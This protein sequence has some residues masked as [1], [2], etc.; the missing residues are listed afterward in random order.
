MYSFTVTS[1]TVDVDHDQSTV[2]TIVNR[3]G[4]CDNCLED[5]G[6]ALACTGHKPQGTRVVVLGGPHSGKSVFVASLWTS[7]GGSYEWVSV[8][9]DGEGPVFHAMTVAGDMEGARAYKAKHKGQWSLE[10]A[11]DTS[12]KVASMRTNAILDAGGL[13][14]EWNMVIASQA[15]YAIVLHKGDDHAVDSRSA[16]LQWCGLMGLPVLHCIHSNMDGNDA[17]DAISGLNRGTTHTDKPATKA[18]SFLLTHT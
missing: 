12:H 4:Q 2:T 15:D 14:S 9:P 1:I 17:Y 8:C 13:R 6:P 10:Y 3:C 18:T 11:Q 7:L 5:E 16:W